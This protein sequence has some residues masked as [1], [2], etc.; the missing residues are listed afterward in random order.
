AKYVCSPP[1]RTQE[2]QHA[3]WEAVRKGWLTAVSSDHCGFD[4]KTHK[5]MGKD[6]FTKIPNGAPG[7]ENRLAVLWTYGVETGKISRQKLVEIFATNPAKINGIFH[8]KGH[9][10]VGY[11]A[12]LVIFDP[13]WRGVMTVE[14]SLQGVDYCTFEGME[15]KGRPDKVYLRGKLTV[16]KGKFIGQKGQGEFIE[17]KPFGL[18]YENFK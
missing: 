13:T 15:Q 18:C 14:G 17:G 1:L 9:I 3:L 12:D 4:W 11:D 10:G 7:L 6:D 16:E 8:R 2:H 5:H